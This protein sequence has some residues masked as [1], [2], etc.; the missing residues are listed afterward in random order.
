MMHDISSQKELK[1]WL[2]N[3][4]Q[5]IVTRISFRIAL[6]I[7]P[8]IQ[9]NSFDNVQKK[10][11]ILKLFRSLSTLSLY[12][13]GLRP[14]ERPDVKYHYPFGIPTVAT[15]TRHKVF[16][17]YP[18]SAIDHDVAGAIESALATLFA[19]DIIQATADLELV[20]SRS[21]EAISKTSQ[22]DNLLTP[23]WHA[24]SEDC[25]EIEFRGE[26]A[27][28]VGHLLTW[29][30][31]YFVD[32]GNNLWR[33]S[34]PKHINNCWDQLKKTISEP[35]W[36]VWI[37]WYEA[38]LYGFQ[39][40][41][42]L[43]RELER[44]KVLIPNNDWNHPGNP[45]HV[46]GIIAELEKQFIG[47]GGVDEEALAQR[48][49]PYSFQATKD[50]IDV[51]PRAPNAV[52]A[53]RNSIYAGVKE[54]TAQTLAL[55]KGNSG[56]ADLAETLQRLTDVLGDRFESINPGDLL[57]AARTVQSDATAFDTPEKHEKLLPK[58]VSSLRDISVS[59]DDLLGL[60]P[61]LRDIQAN[62]LS[63]KIQ[64]ANLEEIE[65]NTKELETTA[66]NSAAVTP[67]AKDALTQGDQELKSA[68]KRIEAAKSDTERA[69]AEADKA[70][71]LSLKLLTI[72]NFVSA[73]LKTLRDEAK[74]VGALA[75]KSAKSGLGKGIESAFSGSVKAGI[76]LLIASCAGPVA[77]I[78]V[79]VAS[80]APL[81]RRA[82]EIEKQVE[83]EANALPP[84]DDI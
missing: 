29:S 28:T 21:A 82:K 25:K 51:V 32:K 77:G 24:I 43:N 79:F 58:A 40:V 39:N 13:N 19:P 83:G 5:A 6:R 49:A 38:R 41:Y 2:E 55:A 64:D 34:C 3:K 80:F 57:M 70:K 1:S 52:D 17:N 75:Y 60:F 20:A 30:E 54:K 35:H 66:L 22:T 33:G 11:L 9:L 12:K 7:L 26:L 68:N 67:N 69:S 50:T 81:G 62:A 63:L 8:L 71:L 56:D 84:Q 42:T 53:L 72:R 65:S 27:T 48:P 37:D 47:L 15:E 16:D 4:S 31:D 23:F 45:A 76:A 73:G 78:A 61:E 44:A 18:Q 46:N 59:L 10:L 74:D 36:R 14:G